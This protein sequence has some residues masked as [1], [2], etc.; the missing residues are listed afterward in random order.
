MKIYFKYFLLNKNNNKPNIIQDIASADID[1]AGLLIPQ[2]EPNIGVEFVNR[3]KSIKGLICPSHV[4]C[5][6]SN[7]SGQKRPII[8]L[9]KIIYKKNID[10]V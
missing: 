4:T 5:N 8:N 3:V 7:N 9:E 2:E 10:P 6:S 1:H